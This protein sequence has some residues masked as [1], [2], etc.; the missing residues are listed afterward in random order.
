MSDY[1]D[2]NE[3]HVCDENCQQQVMYVAQPA[4][5]SFSP[6]DIAGVVIHGGASV[7]GALSTAGTMLARECFAAAAYGRIQKEQARIAEA[8]EAARVQMADS[9]RQ[10]IE[11]PSA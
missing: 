11:G 2:E 1:E 4:A 3:E 6:W 9:L 5:W 8:A 7:L 10:M